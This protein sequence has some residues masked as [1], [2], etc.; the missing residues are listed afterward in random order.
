MKALALLTI[1]GGLALLARR[2]G[3]QVR[4]RCMAACDRMIDEI[5][6]GFPPKRI[7]SDLE[8]LR[9]LSERMIALLE[10]QRRATEQAPSA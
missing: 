4:A 2:F 1:I 6:D 9:T 7:M 3:P 8:A 10:E 5:P